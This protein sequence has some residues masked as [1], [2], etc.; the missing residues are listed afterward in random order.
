MDANKPTDSAMLLLEVNN[1][2]ENMSFG[3]KA[4][5]WEHG[6]F[7]KLVLIYGF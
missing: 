5:L 3:M 1:L 4:G 2:L 7:I 6:T